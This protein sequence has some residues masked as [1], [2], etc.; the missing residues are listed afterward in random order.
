MVDVIPL[1]G[2]PGRDPRSGAVLFGPEERVNDL[3]P[4]GEH[5]DADVRFGL[6]V[7][8]LAGHHSWLDKAGAYTRLDFGKLAPRWREP[9]KEMALL[10]LN[11]ALA[12]ARAPDSPMAQNWP[13]MQEPV[14]PVEAAPT[15]GPSTAL[16]RRCTSSASRGAV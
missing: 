9:A 15:L 7:W 11:P 16:A 8:D 1:F 4:G 10:Q 13:H 12:A 6:D 3:V 2:A 5:I 14:K